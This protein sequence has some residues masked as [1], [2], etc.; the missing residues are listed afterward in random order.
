MRYW[1]IFQKHSVRWLGYS[2]H[3]NGCKV[4]QY[5]FSSYQLK[6]F[7]AYF[8]CMS[9]VI[10]TICCSGIKVR[11]MQKCCYSIISYLHFQCV[12]LFL[13]H[14]F[15]LIKWLS[16][17]TWTFLYYCLNISLIIWT[18]TVSQNKW[19]DK[20]PIR[21]RILCRHATFDTLYD[22]TAAVWETIGLAVARLKWNKM[23]KIKKRG[24]IIGGIG[25]GIVNTNLCWCIRYSHTS[26]FLY[27][28]INVVH[29]NRY[30]Y[31][32]YFLVQS[33]ATL[34]C[35]SLLFW[36]CVAMLPTRGSAGENKT[37]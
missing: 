34:S 17:R 21:S 37:Q 20:S 2:H 7:V 10:T 9:N 8:D 33:L 18:E 30:F 29:S 12:S 24:G 3:S 36:Y 16:P 27:N 6:L 28:N 11:I 14:C 19:R 25:E 26:P 4:H 35:S 5:T 1:Y 31:V 13:P 23:M 32:A 22:V 15:Y